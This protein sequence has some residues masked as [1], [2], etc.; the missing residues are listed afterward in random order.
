MGVSTIEIKV[1]GYHVDIYG[2]VNN[3]RYVEFLEEARWA[4]A[5]DSLD[6]AQWQEQGIG[7]LTSTIAGRLS[8]VKFW[9][10][11]LGLLS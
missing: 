1:R 11:G 3:A 4:F 2:H 10:F 9:K 8:W 6:L 5:E 7:F